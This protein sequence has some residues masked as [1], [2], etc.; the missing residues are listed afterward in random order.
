M[1]RGSRPDRSQDVVPVPA[2]EPSEPDDQVDVEDVV[3][4]DADVVEPE[5][6]SDVGDGSPIVDR[7]QRT[8]LPTEVVPPEPPEGGEEGTQGQ[9]PDAG[10]SEEDL[11]DSGASAEVPRTWWQ[12]VD[13]AAVP[14]VPY[15]WREASYDES[16]K[17]SRAESFAAE[18]G[19]PVE[20]YI[21]EVNVHTRQLLADGRLCMFV[22][23]AALR[24][25]LVDGRFKNQHETGTSRGMLGRGPFEERAMG[26]DGEEDP[27]SAPV[28]GL[29]T[30]APESTEH[31]YQRT[32]YGRAV[33]VF[34]DSLRPRT[35]F[36]VGDSLDENIVEGPT[37]WPTPVNDPDEGSQ[38]YGIDDP[39][40]VERIDDLRRNYYVEAQYWG[41]VNVGDIEMVYVDDYEPELAAELRDA[42]LDV[43]DLSH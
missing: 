19:M 42:G 43:R 15:E 13:R 2:P 30:D 11:A 16:P 40:A 37:T 31:L 10:Q 7:S 18:R 21:E 1:G 28:Y 4:V 35:T 39:L 8:D 41:P 17:W 6:G 27:T 26:V 5:Q 9:D 25:V 32:H 34:R 22:P 3:D 12:D 38:L 20:D 29:V 24:R 36:T 14:E 23:P 33:V